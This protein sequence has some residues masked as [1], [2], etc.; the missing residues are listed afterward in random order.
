[1]LV[2]YR[3]Q[4]GAP[5]V[6]GSG[7][8]SG[9]MK[10]QAQVCVLIVAVALVGATAASA[11]P[12]GSVG[13][14]QAQAQSVLSQIQGLD[15]NLEH[16]VEAYNLAN[17]KLARIEADLR[18]NKVELKLAKSN[19]KHARINLSQRLVQMYTS[20]GDNASLDVL[21]GARSIDDLITRIDTVNRASDQSTQVLKEVKIYGAAVRTRRARLK[22]A[23]IQ[24]AK[25]VAESEAQKASIEGQLAQRRQLLSSIKSEIG[26]IQAAERAQQARLAAQARA[27]LAAPQNGVE[28]L[29]ASAGAITTQPS[30]TYAP[31]PSRY[32]GVVGI[33]MRYL[34]TPY[35]YG[36]ASPGG[37][38]CSGFV[39][40]VFGQMG[41]SLPH[42]A[43]AQYGFGTP[44]SRAD[45]QPGDLVFFNG[46]GHVGIY[47]GGGQFIHSPHTGDVVKISSLTGWYSSTYVGAR[48]I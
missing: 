30:T 35:V 4:T 32:G 25:L 31:P 41:V 20:G 24:Q 48:R 14:K 2:T 28:V 13:A 34:G 18:E 43:A 39:M 9:F 7:A 29:A 15:G 45:L 38:D 3:P 1:V 10:R 33:A 46:L 5:V 47:I 44:V 11:T 42:N 26:R 27:R 8:L 40:Y 12:G 16:A 36:G 17:Q 23:H 37:F 21:L 22:D 19:L 6:A